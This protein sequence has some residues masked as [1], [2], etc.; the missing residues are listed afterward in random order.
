MSVAATVLTALLGVTVV[1]IGVRFLCTPEP[2]AAG[3]G[4]PA[5]ASGDASAYLAIKGV[6]DGM[7][8]VITLVLLIVAGHSVIGWFLLAASLVP[9]GDAVIVLR[10]HGSKVLAY[11]MHGG[12]GVAMLA[13]A[14]LQFAG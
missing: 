10:H 7:L 13:I 11:A 14:A 8:G 6:R 5:S 9:F 12:T 1:W 3:Y 2:A 4:V